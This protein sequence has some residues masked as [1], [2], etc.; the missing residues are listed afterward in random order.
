MKWTKTTSEGVETPS[1]TASKRARSED[2]SVDARN[3]ARKRANEREGSGNSEDEGEVFGYF[4]SLPNDVMRDILHRL[5]GVQLAQAACAC[6]DFERLINQNEELWYRAS[7]ALEPPT[8]MRDDLVRD[9]NT[10]ANFTWK[11]LYVWRLHTLKRCA[12]VDAMTFSAKSER[13][14]ESSMTVSTGGGSATTSSKQDNRAQRRFSRHQGRLA[15][16]DRERLFTCDPVVKGG[17]MCIIHDVGINRFAPRTLIWAPKG[18]LLAVTLIVEGP[19][20]STLCNKILL[21][22]PQHALSTF[23]KRRGGGSLTMVGRNSDDRPYQVDPSEAR[24]YTGP[25]IKNILA[26]PPGVQCSQMAFAPCGSKINFLHRDRMETGLFS[27]DCATTI[28]SLYGPSNGDLSPVPPPSEFVTK[29]ASGGEDLVFAHS[30]ISNSHQSLVLD[31]TQESF[32][33]R[34]DGIPTQPLSDYWP[35]V[36]EFDEL[37]SDMSISE[38]GETR[39]ALM[40]ERIDNPRPRRPRPEPEVQPADAFPQ[41]PTVAEEVHQ[42]EHQPA[43]NRDGVADMDD[44]KEV[45]SVEQPLWWQ[46]PFVIGRSLIQRLAST[47]SGQARIPGMGPPQSQTKRSVSESENSDTTCRRESSWWSNIPN[48]RK[49]SSVVVREL[50]KQ[51]LSRVFV[52]QLSRSVQ[53]VPPAPNDRAKRGYWLVP[54]AIPEF[55]TP[56]SAFLIMTPAPS[57]E[58]IAAGHIHPFIGYENEKIFEVIK[59]CLVT[60]I[61]PHTTFQDPDLSIPFLFSGAPGGRLVGWAMDEGVFSRVIRWTVDDNGDYAN[62]P[63]D[64][65]LELKVLDF[66]ILMLSE[67]ITGENEWNVKHDELNM[68]NYPAF[69]SSRNIA[70]LSVK[71]RI[72][73]YSVSALQWSRSGK[74][75]LLLL[76]TH[77]A[78][79]F[80]SQAGDYYTVHQWV[81]WDPAKE[82]LDPSSPVYLPNSKVKAHGCLS[83]GARFIPSE[84]FAANCLEKME[85]F[86]QG[87]NLWSPD[88]TAVAF[89]LN[90]PDGNDYIVMQKFPQVDLEDIKAKSER[91]ELPPLQQGDDVSC[92]PYYLNYLDIP[93]DFVCEG[94]YV[95]WSP[96]DMFSR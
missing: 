66:E 78:H 13:A 96:G 35:E 70:V 54:S 90:M 5:D 65:G 29:V 69:N 19:E 27:L 1:S 20:A 49:L 18:E 2:A 36:D 95:V 37:D 51:P 32:M 60:E 67:Q 28:T 4:S 23:K 79:E 72:V 57:D 59:E 30:P 87:N 33:L 7:C 91:G 86:P 24:G 89:A 40:Q 46:K 73:A 48:F 41:T 22:A 8:C 45:A 21:S 50:P 75:L 58:K 92:V 77:L 10:F 63:P 42:L 39:I 17:I 71:N 47:V 62:I 56:F 34:I 83:F 6:R 25:P 74:R 85:Q 64:M 12:A 16:I 68:R 94:S 93:F 3:D 61:T 53:W 88:E 43:F 80:P 76:A 44:L 82:A 11:E 81:C 26:L 9:K 52:E 38:D 31:S 14:K 55:Y 84:T 15:V